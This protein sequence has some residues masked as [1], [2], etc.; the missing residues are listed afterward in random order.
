MAEFDR[1]EEI[2]LAN[3]HHRRR[4]AAGRIVRWWS[5]KLEK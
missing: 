1:E 5:K 4:Q 2:R 3:V